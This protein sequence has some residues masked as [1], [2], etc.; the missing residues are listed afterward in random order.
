MQRKIIRTRSN[1][2]SFSKN[3]FRWKNIENSNLPI[4]PNLSRISRLKPLF[5]PLDVFIFISKKILLLLAPFF[6]PWYSVSKLYGITI[7]FLRN[8]SSWKILQNSYVLERSR[9]RLNSIVYFAILIF[10]FSLGFWVFSTKLFYR[11]RIPM[12]GLSASFFFLN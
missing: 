6:L 2:F 7:F 5:Y 8:F 9:L 10:K 12:I 3:H 11:D 1:F 4:R